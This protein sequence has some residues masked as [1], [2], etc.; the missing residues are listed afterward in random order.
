VATDEDLTAVDDQMR[1]LEELVRRH[2]LLYYAGEPE[3]TDA[4][5]DA[6][7]AELQGLEAE[8]PEL[9][10]ADTPTEHILDGVSTLFAP[11]RHEHPMLSLDKAH[12]DEEIQAFLGRFAGQAMTAAIKFD[13]LS[14]SARYEKGRLVGF[15]TRGD[16]EVGEDVTVNARGMKNLPE[17]LTRAVSCEIRGEVVMRHSDFDAYNEAHPDKPLANARNAA[18]GTLRAKDRAKVADRPL[19]FEPFDLIED[20]VTHDVMARVREL[21]LDAEPTLTTD[22]PDKIIA[23]MHKII[24]DREIFDFDLD[25]VVIRLADREAFDAVGSTSHH[26]R[27]AIAY[28]PSAVRGESRIDDVIWQVGKTGR[29]APVAVI[30]PVFLGGTTIRRA[31]LHNLSV[32]AQRDIQIGD[33]ITLYRA[34]DVIPYVEGPILS[35]R[36]GSQRPVVEPANC[37]SCGTPLIEEGESR[38]LQCENTLGCPAQ[39]LGRLDYWASRAAADIDAI[40]TKWIQRFINAGLLLTP[41]D[42]YGPL[43]EALVAER[44]RFAADRKA[45]A[46]FEGM[47]LRLVEKMIASID[48]SQNVGL[49]KAII[50]WSIPLCSQG[51]AKRLCHAGYESAEQ[52]A[53]ATVEELEEVDDIGPASAASIA[54]FFSLQPTLDQIERLRS[55]DVNLDVLDADRPVRAASSSPL[56][57]KT[58]VISGTLEKT[59]RKAAQAAIEQAGGKAS[60]SVS[61]KTDLLV[62]GPS[63]G[64][65]L[66][67]AQELGVEII[68]EP[69]LLSLLEQAGVHPS[70]ADE[71]SGPHR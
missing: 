22:D 3:I 26:P 6:L 11:V 62:A 60:G 21:G 64:S 66:A 15:A 51:A 25:G 59:S 42:F 61:K 44:D 4:E 33:R 17:R 54:T 56:A 45:A 39:T 37:P 38:L 57:G 9:K 14:G 58:V 2:S 31:T 12:T 7:F 10:S 28:K 70:T 69:A 1:E 46:R 41:A 20:G 36:D 43:R 55:Y 18:A 49:R 48:A 13:G 16:G 19:S 24:E 47:G 23:W 8:H 27:G 52:L 29:V 34:G 71:P 63:A 67:K 5:F 30:E 35:A 68:D 32:I 53:A 65:K 50:G 40:G